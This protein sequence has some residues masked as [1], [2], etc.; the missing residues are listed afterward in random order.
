MP[1]ASAD[2]GRGQAVLAWDHQDWKPWLCRVCERLAEIMIKV[3]DTP[4]GC[5]GDR[6]PVKSSRMGWQAN[7]ATRRSSISLTH[8]CSGWTMDLCW[9]C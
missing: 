4:H 2:R 9:A 8:A 7:P 1:A 3:E 6:P 5:L